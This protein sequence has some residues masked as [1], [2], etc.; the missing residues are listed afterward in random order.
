MNVKKIVIASG[1]LGLVSSTLVACSPAS[2]NDTAI[3]GQGNQNSELR[4]VAVTVG[5]LG[6]PF[7]VLMGRGAEAEAKKIGGENVKFTVV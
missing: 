3:E 6:N 1:V 7:F 2:Q 5:D 4:S